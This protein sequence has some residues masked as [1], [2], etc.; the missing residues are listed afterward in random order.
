MKRWSIPCAALI[1]IV[2]AWAQDKPI[3]RGG[4]PNSGKPDQSLWEKELLKDRI[5]SNAVELQ[6]KY[7]FP[8]ENE[9]EKNEIF[10]KSI[11]NVSV[12]SRGHI[13]VPDYQL[14]VVYEFA[15]DGKFLSKYAKKGQ[16]P[17]ELQNPHNVMFDKDRIVVMDL[18]TDRIAYF[19]RDWTYLNSLR[20]IKSYYPFAIGK[21]SEI[22]CYDRHQ[23]RS[24][25]IH[26]PQGKEIKVVETAYYPD[27]KK[28]PLNS[29]LMRMSPWDT[30]WIIYKAL[31]IVREYSLEGA[32]LKEMNL[33]NVSSDYVKA[34]KKE[35][36]NWEKKGLNQHYEI[37]K[38]VA[39]LNGNAYLTGGGLVKPIFQIDGSGKVNNVFFI[40]PQFR[41]FRVCFHVG[42]DEDGREEFYVLND[43]DGERSIGVYGRK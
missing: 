29:V 1:L 37:I 34:N 27:R 26:D 11:F 15:K 24:L 20:L 17:G 3:I 6:L 5:P 10:F 19:D 14:C 42:L 9:I 2:S 23:E 28:S 33:L 31:G 21:N 13:Y 12:D 39:F 4:S 7:S 30:V 8:L 43:N 32:V 36:E 41:A 25:V 22:Y 16:G 40:K 18:S 35:N 38:D